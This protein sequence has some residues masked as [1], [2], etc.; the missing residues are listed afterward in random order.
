[1]DERQ[2]DLQR[3]HDEQFD[4]QLEL[5]DLTPEQTR[6]RARELLQQTDTDRQGRIAFTI[7][8]HAALL[9]SPVLTTEAR[10]ERLKGW[11]KGFGLTLD[12]L[13]DDLV[14]PPREKGDAQ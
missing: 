3:W 14:R 12:E 9:R 4:L 8:V 10:E 7:R 6:E 13:V 5:E 2:F 1:M 11:C